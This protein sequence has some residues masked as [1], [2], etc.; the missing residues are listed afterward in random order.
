[1]A[2]DARRQK[3]Q[4]GVFT[5]LEHPDHYDL[6]AYLH[7]RGIGHLLTR[8]DISGD[9]FPQAMCDLDLMNVRSA[10]LFPDLDGAARQASRDV[11]S[12]LLGAVGAIVARHAAGKM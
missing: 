5:I 4:Q 12:V 1:L 2:D 7:S 11:R 10:S 9:N 3:A 8:Y 6:E